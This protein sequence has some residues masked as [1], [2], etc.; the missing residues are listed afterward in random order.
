MVI[1]PWGKPDLMTPAILVLGDAGSF[2][3]GFRKG[4]YKETFT[5]LDALRGSVEAL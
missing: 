4:R 5:I 1:Y 3:G 2:Y